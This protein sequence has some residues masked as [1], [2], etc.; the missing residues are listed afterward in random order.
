MGGLGICLALALALGERETLTPNRSVFIA[1]SR[2]TLA[3]THSIEKVRWEEDYAVVAPTPLQSE[4]VLH[5]LEA[6]IKGSAAG[7]EPGVDAVLREGWYVYTPPQKIH[8]ELALSR[9]FY[10]ADYELCIEGRCAPMSDF[11]KSNGAVTYLR[12][13]RLT[14]VDK[15][16]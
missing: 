7:M 12:G 8:R 16:P 1:A 3:W 11:L 9:S 14:E 10:T 2:F 5:A 4:P 15:K 6:R 13:C